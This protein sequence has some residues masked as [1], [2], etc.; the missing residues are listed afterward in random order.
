MSRES[1]ASQPHNARFLD[2]S[3]QFLRRTDRIIGIHLAGFNA[4]ILAVRINHNRHYGLIYYRMIVRTDVNNRTGDAGMHRNGNVA[5]T[6]PYLLP[7]ENKLAFLDNRLGRNPGV[8]TH[9]KNNPL[10]QR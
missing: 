1:C 6:L 7:P 5:G 4:F 10:G 3:T 9:R 2:C 8:L